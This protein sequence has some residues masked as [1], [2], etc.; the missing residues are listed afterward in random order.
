MF[1]IAVILIFGGETLGDF[2]FAM[3]VGV[4]S[5]TYSSIFIATPVLIAWKEREPGYRARGA[6][7]KELMG[8]V[9]PF[10]EDNIVARVDGE[11]GPE[12]E[13]EA[14]EPVEEGAAP[15]LDTDFSSDGDSEP[16]EGV[17]VPAPDE[18]L[19]EEELAERQRKREI[20]ERRKARR[21]AR[22]R[23]HGRQR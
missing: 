2:A 8:I 19:S 5:G 7:I 10:P 22:K 13:L 3:M 20:R 12:P 4:L 16:E 14:G 15:S 23:G 11:D 6:R 9:P 21:A 18:G 17:T 1:L